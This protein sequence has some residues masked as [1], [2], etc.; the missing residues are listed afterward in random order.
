[1]SKTVIGLFDN[2]KEAL[3]VAEALGD[4]GVDRSN[5]VIERREADDSRYSER[6]STILSRRG[7]P[8][9]D[10]DFFCEGLR[11]GGTLVVAETQDDR[12]DYVAGIMNDHDPVDIDA[13]LSMWREDGY[14]RHDPAAPRLTRTEAET[15]RARV[16]ETDV[17]DRESIQIVEEELKVGKREVGGG[18]V[19]VHSWVEEVPVSER[20][21]LREEFVSVERRDADKVVTDPDDLFE[22]K[23]IV[24]KEVDE[25]LVVEKEA[26]VTGE[27]V[28][29]KEAA[30]TVETVKD[31]VRRT[32]VD[33]DRTA[34]D[35]DDNVET[36]STA[37]AVTTDFDAYRSD[38]KTHCSQTYPNA[39]FDDY[40]PAYRFGYRF[41]ERYPDRDFADAEPELRTAYERDHG[42]GTWDRI[43]DAV[44]HAYYRAKTAV[45]T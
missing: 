31:S 1:M 8:E 20:V 45:T 18:A 40:E 25:E 21:R 32:E 15:E 42:E 28:V 39:R 16:A 23:T 29:K 14:E 35:I 13:R 10:V 44:R 9:D 17:E 38:F 26:R 34:N 41:A 19:R 36:V 2:H 22:E 37:R 3:S 11:R 5:I 33:I 27:V 12:A 7:V 24:M 43:K 6:I 30:E 4:A